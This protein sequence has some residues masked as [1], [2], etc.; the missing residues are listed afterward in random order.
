MDFEWDDNKNQLNQ[1]K[2][3]LSFED[4][5]AVFEDENRV[6]IPD[7]RKDYGEPRWFTIGKAVETIILVVFTVRETVVRLISARKASQ[8]EKERYHGQ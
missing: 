7:L 2:H 8:K 5:K 4:S 3:G 6:V 1:Q